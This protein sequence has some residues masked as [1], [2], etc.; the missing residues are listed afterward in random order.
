V[1]KDY[2][3]ILGV[4]K[5]ASEK[6]I[7]KAYRRLALKYHPDKNPGDKSAEEKFKEAS[8]AYEVLRDPE[9]RKAYDT[10]G[11]AGLHDMGW[12]GFGSTEDIYANFGD[13]FSDL[14]GPRFHRQAATQPRR[15]HDLQYAVTIPF[16]HSIHGT[17]IALRAN[18]PV[19]CETCGGHGNSGG[20]PTP[21]T[22]CGGSGYQSRQAKQ[23]GGFFS[24]SQ[25]CSVC[26]GTGA[27][28]GPPCFACGGKG[29][30]AK[31]RTI[32]V[33]IPPGVKSGQKLRL[34]GQGEPGLRGGPA[35]NLYVIVN[36]QDDRNFERKGLNIISSVKVPFTTAALG[37]EV[38]ISTVHGSATLK[39]PKGV[40]SG[41]KLRLAGQGV[42]T[43]SGKKGDHLAKVLITVPKKLKKKQKELLEEL[44]KLE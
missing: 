31:P 19:A 5:K 14:F 17:K 21:C 39:V 27:K 32:D 15:G 41:T 8:E 4:K 2:Y 11:Q 22:A 18:T 43:R 9:K 3:E 20:Q 26:G 25:P 37:G 40:Q 12:Q 28:H 44:K 1:A 35:G 23:S 10:R 29:Q 6:E 7:K 33:T 16:M 36:V 38:S 24:V 34:A 13:I 30:V 42:H